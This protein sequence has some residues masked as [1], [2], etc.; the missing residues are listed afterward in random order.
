MSARGLSIDTPDDEGVDSSDEKNSENMAASALLTLLSSPSLKK[1]GGEKKNQWGPPLKRQK[2]DPSMRK[3]ALRNKTKKEEKAPEPEEAPSLPSEQRNIEQVVAAAMNGAPVDPAKVVEAGR[4]LYR[5]VELVRGKYKGR[6]ACVVGMT[7]KKYRVRVI[8]VEHQLEFYPSMFKNPTVIEG[9]AFS[10]ADAVAPAATTQTQTQTQMV[11][12]TQPKPSSNGTHQ[13]SSKVSTMSNGPVLSIGCPSG[14][15]TS[16]ETDG[17]SSSAE[18][19]RSGSD[20][21]SGGHGSM[22]TSDP[23]CMTPKTKEQLMR[24]MEETSAE[25]R[26]AK[27]MLIQ[28]QEARHEVDGYRTASPREATPRTLL[29]NS[30]AQRP[31]ASPC[32]VS[33]R[34]VVPLSRSLTL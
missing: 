32:G 5:R 31:P 24:L 10:A 16:R 8:G 1:N 12:P 23:A 7:A 11:L 15:T 21:S 9:L 18:D 13:E 26:R 14:I 20:G 19:T 29:N 28:N 22:P 25:M 17:V 4:W 6:H 2:S 34:P 3:S 27:N 30:I 33:P